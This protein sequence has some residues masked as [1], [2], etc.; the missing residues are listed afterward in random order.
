MAASVRFAVAVHMLVLLALEREGRTSAYIAG[1][2]NTNPVVVRRLLG[3]L[4]RAGLVAGHAGPGGGFTL[5]KRPR[6]VSLADVYRAVESKPLIALHEGPN[7]ACPVGKNV[8]S[9][10]AG[11]SRRAERATLDA[12]GALT[13]AGVV[14]RV[15]TRAGGFLRAS[16]GKSRA[17]RR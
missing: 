14:G 9:V 2:V 12:L 1:S 8:G 17:G 10:L 6:Q 5:R 3:R 13:L 7:P 11:V 16:P 4:R 15:K